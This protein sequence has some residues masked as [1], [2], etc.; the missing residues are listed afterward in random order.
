MLKFVARPAARIGLGIAAIL[1]VLLLVMAYRCG[2]RGCPDVDALKGYAPDQASVILDHRGA[3]VGKLYVT[4]RVIVRL[5]SLPEHV[6]NAFIAMEDKRFW[7][8]NGV[9]WL[10]VVGA[11]WQNVKELGVAEG[12]STITM[13]LARNAF[14][15]HL[16]ANQRRFWRKIGEARV[17]HTIEHKFSKREILEL[18]LNQIYFGN[19]AYGIEAAA[20]EYFAKPASKLT[21]SEAAVLAAL[22]RAPSRLNPR[23]NRE[24]ALEGRRIVLTRMAEQGLITAEEADQ[25]GKARLRV[26]RGQLKSQEVAPYFV[27]AIRRQLEEQLG[28]AIYTE[29]YTIHT[30]LDVGLQRLAEEELRRQMHA[31]ESGAYGRYRHTTYAVAVRD[32]TFQAEGTPY[33]QAAVVFMDARTGDVRALIG[34]RDYLD[35]QYNR[36]VS[37]ERQPGSAFKPFVYAAAVAAGYPPS[38]R[39][40]DEPIRMVLD[41]RR[42]W[43]P[44]NYDG[45]YA[46]VV[47]MRQAL[48]Q[49]RNV[50]TVRLAMDVGV[51][52]VVAMAQQTGLQ[53]T[54]PNVPS[55]V[56]GAAEVTPL[57]LTSAYATFATLGTHPEPRLVTRV[58]DRDGRIIWSQEPFAS[59]VLDPAV[60]FIVTDMLKDVVDYGTGTAVRAVGFSGPAAGKTGTTNDAADVWFVGYTPRLVGTI[61]LGFDDR[62]TVV[63][64]ATGGELAAPI[65]GRIMRR[66]NE[67]TSDWLTPSGVEL[68]VIDEFGYA[69]GQNCPMVGPTREEYFLT[70]TAP[71]ES[72]YTS[73]TFYDSLYGDSLYGYPADT[74]L[75]DDAWWERLKRRVFGADRIDTL[76][77]QR[78]DTPR[79]RAEP[80]RVRADTPRL[81]GVPVRRPDSWPRTDTI[82]KPKPDTTKKPP[83]DTTKKPPPDTLRADRPSPAGY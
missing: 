23:T 33:L 81:L 65:W 83:P 77:V 41:R 35:S 57:H 59:T 42:T 75:T 51:D 55:V 20:Q 54:I 31:I 70:G 61:W 25:A 6:P 17:A 67:R 32:T 16:P 3:E 34:G 39:L 45:S 24:L 7:K 58:V 22:P 60:A 49:S 66:L 52:Q 15:D 2:L 80:P 28:D 47:T 50:A 62:K 79:V 43:E 64:G 21:L 74:V 18:Y 71:L 72:C 12:S 5:D 37:A 1:A 48:T 13:Q 76:P 4:R 10:R 53:G 82:R 56:L 26:R 68:R 73:Q 9:D 8:H 27:A 14:P 40:V 38:Y 19:G 11:A 69:Y 30:T 63:R 78:A 46:G 36:A 44:K 29:G